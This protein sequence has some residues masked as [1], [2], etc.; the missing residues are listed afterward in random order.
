MTHNRLN[1]LAP[2]S[3][4]R[5]HYFCS[6]GKDYKGHSHFWAE[7]SRNNQLGSIKSNLLSGWVRKI[8]CFLKE[9]DI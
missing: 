6:R 2:V 7:G 9:S 4:E 5:Q 1:E 3:S 8:I